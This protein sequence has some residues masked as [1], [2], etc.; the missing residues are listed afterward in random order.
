L[1]GWRLQ[2]GFAGDR[3]P[4]TWPARHPDYLLLD[5]ATTHVVKKPADFGR[6][7]VNRA[8]KQPVGRNLPLFS[9]R[10]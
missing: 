7:H 2:T 9:Q 1:R 3:Q 6:M 10:F 8:G 4:G 5:K